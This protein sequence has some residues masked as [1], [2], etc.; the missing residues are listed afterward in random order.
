VQVYWNTALQA[1][2]GHSNSMRS[3]T[4][5]SD[6]NLLPALHVSS[7]WIVEG[8]ANTLWSSS[9]YRSTC[10]AMWDLTVGLGHPLGRLSFLKFQRGPK[11]IVYD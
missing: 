5:S 7:D 10:N 4:F 11:H 2:E 3:I 1:L 9:D 6:G 8:K